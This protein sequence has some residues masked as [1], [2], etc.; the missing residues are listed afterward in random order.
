M[1]TLGHTRVLANWQPSALDEETI[2]AEFA[3]LIRKLVEQA[4]GVPRTRTQPC[5]EVRPPNQNAVNGLHRDCSGI[6]QYII[7]WSNTL[8]T[9]V[10]FNDGSWLKTK[11]GDVLLLENT[12]VQH[13]APTSHAA[14]WAAERWFVRVRVTPTG[15]FQYSA[16]TRC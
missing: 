10:R 6:A 9:I 3:V 5:V 2:K 15:R 16:F 7:V 14:M 1:H 12:E 11:A 13:D 8:P 4:G